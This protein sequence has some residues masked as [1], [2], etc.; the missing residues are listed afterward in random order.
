MVKRVDE[1]QAPGEAV[2]QGNP[3]AAAS[4][5]DDRVYE[6]QVRGQ[7]DQKWAGWLEDLEVQY[8]DGG[9]M[10]LSGRLVDQAALMG[11]LTKL[12]HMNLELIS[13]NRKGKG[14]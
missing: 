11:V 8:L 14:R 12:S 3:Q 5:I 10:L 13:V 4:P 9:E 7:L 2:D 1:I 6:I